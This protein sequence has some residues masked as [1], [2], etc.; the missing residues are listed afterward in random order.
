MTP[1]QRA[2]QHVLVGRAMT[3]ESISGL[4]RVGLAR[5]ELKGPRNV[6]KNQIAKVSVGV[7]R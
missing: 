1:D 3:K 7:I 5:G 4:C 2:G 6:P